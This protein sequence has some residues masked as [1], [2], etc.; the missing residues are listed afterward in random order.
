[1]IYTIDRLEGTLAVCEDGDG[2]CVSIETSKL[3]DGVRSGDII[4]SKNGVFTVDTATA[5]K[6]RS[7]MASLQNSLFDGSSGR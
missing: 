6:R 3:P 2:A 4:V 7:D 5:E 1:M